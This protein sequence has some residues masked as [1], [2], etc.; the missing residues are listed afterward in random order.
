MPIGQND[1]DSAPL[2]V[3]SAA[4]AIEAILF[5]TE[6][7]GK[8]TATPVKAAP[9]DPATKEAA[10][11][12][13]DEPEATEDSTDEADVETEDEPAETEETEDETPEQP[14]TFK[15]KVDGQD[16]EVTLDEALA[17][18]SRTADYT[19]KTQKLADD[20][21]AFEVEQN[22]IRAERQ[23]ITAK[24][25]EVEQTFAGVQEPDWDKLL[26]EDPTSFPL[27]HA[28]WQ[29]HKEQLAAVQQQRQLYEQQLRNDAA[30]QF[31]AHLAAEAGKLSAAIPEWS[32]AEVAKQEK[33]KLVDY[34][35]VLGFSNDELAGIADHRA[36]IVLRKAMLFDA[37]EQAKADAA[38]KAKPKID[39][40]KAATP[41]PSSETRR[42]TSELTRRKQRLAKTHSVDDAASIIE[43]ML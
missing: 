14:K 12:P 18:Y 38:K 33:A 11:T 16:V 27:I 20:R 23:Q 8:P 30:Q 41:G 31:Q 9:S 5:P 21:K 6:D 10:E 17:G 35:H 7:K 26:A 36:M 28:T 22:A 29:R 42:E 19:R 4:P 15:A 3:D 39:K 34:A 37:A 1:G 2:T 40:V 32:D 25:A 13:D 43:L 24:L